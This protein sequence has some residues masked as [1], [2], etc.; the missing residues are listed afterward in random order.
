MTP[1]TLVVPVYRGR[2][3]TIDMDQIRARLAEGQSPTR[4]AREMG[5]SRGTVYKAKAKGKD[6]ESGTAAQGPLEVREDP[7]P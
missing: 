3:P 5:I 4:I 2:P 7:A 1:R 6:G